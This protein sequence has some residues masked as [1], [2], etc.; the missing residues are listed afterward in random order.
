MWFSQPEYSYTF[1]NT[2]LWNQDFELSMDI[3]V[4]RSWLYNF[5]Q[6]L[7]SVILIGSFAWSSNLMQFAISPLADVPFH[8]EGTN[9]ANI[10]EGRRVRPQ[11]QVA[12]LR[13]AW[14]QGGLQDPQQPQ[15]QQMQW[16]GLDDDYSLLNIL[17]I[18]LIDLNLTYC[19]TFRADYIVPEMIGVHA[20]TSTYIHYLISKKNKN[21]D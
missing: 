18:L 5:S 4:T 17:I 12:W 8:Q 14:L 3:I 11:V 1:A 21:I 10:C 20:S 7:Q 19:G 9:D 16:Q 6:S 2:L 15:H 13:F